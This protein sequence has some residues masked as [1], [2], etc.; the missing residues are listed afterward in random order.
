MIRDSNSSMKHYKNI[1]FIPP[2]YKRTET[3]FEAFSLRLTRRK[4]RG[5]TRRNAE[6]VLINKYKNYIYYKNIN[7]N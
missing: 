7:T 3:S 2:R 4:P 5:E 1:Q 6:T